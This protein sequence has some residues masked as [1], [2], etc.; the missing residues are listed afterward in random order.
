MKTSE[1][2]EIRY[3]K[4]RQKI[5]RKKVYVSADTPGATVEKDFDVNQGRF[6]ATGKHFKYKDEKVKGPDGKP[7][8]QRPTY[9]HAHYR[10]K[11]SSKGGDYR[12]AA[13]MGTVG[14]WLNL[15]GATRDHIA[16]AIAKV[17]SSPEYKHLLSIGFED[18]STAGDLKNGTLNFIGD[19]EPPIGDE[20]RKTVRVR[21]KILAN[22]NIRTYAGN[23]D[24]HAGRGQAPHPFTTKT[25]PHSTPDERIAKSMRAS[26]EVVAKTYLVQSKRRF[27]HALKNH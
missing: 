22:G 12:P 14:E 15:M 5:E 13:I 7:E 9:D 2:F 20:K 17:R 11:S 1:L 4:P 23:D 26:I 21:R 19:Y 25:D 18:K 6:V 3:N 24:H 16:P 10:P 8:M 27:I